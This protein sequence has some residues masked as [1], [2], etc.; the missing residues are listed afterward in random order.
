[1]TY[2]CPAW[3]FVAETHLLK[4]QRVQNKV[5]CTIGNFPRHTSI[6][7]MHVAF[8]VPYVY[9]YITKLCRRQAEI[10]HNHE[11]VNVGNIGQ[12]EAPRRK[13]KGLNLET[14]ICTKVQV[15]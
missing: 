9:G 2:A 11:N 1:M 4:L 13:H 10:V 8:Q 3:K 12:G 14:V 15:S 6:R 5:L 7:D